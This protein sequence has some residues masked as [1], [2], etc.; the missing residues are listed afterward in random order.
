MSAAQIIVTLG[1]IHLTGPEGT[2]R[3]GVW[4]LLPW[5]VVTIRDR[6]VSFSR[7]SL[8]TPSAW[9]TWSGCV[10]RTGSCAR[11]AAAPCIP[12]ACRSGRQ[13][14]QRAVTRLAKW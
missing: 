5:Q 13:P 9:I 14:G 1:D 7:G 11:I 10:G 6:W 8:P 4:S 3:F 12:N 2:V